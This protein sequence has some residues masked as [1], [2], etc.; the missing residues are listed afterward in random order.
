[1]PVNWGHDKARRERGEQKT[2]RTYGQKYGRGI[3]VGTGGAGS[4]ARKAAE[5]RGE[6]AQG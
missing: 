4:G 3:V 6:A 5:T 1:M 2:R